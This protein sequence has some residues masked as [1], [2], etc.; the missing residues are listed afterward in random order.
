M[1]DS[2]RGGVHLPGNALGLSSRVVG[3][4]TELTSSVSF[5]QPGGGSFL[6]AAHADTEL[7]NKM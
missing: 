7:V 2:E 5:V 3:E 4:K 6:A 1:S